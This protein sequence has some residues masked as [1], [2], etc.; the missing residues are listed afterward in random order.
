MISKKIIETWKKWKHVSRFKM[1]NSQWHF[2]IAYSGIMLSKWTQI[3]LNFFPQFFTYCGTDMDFGL[4][5]GSRGWRACER[6]KEKPCFWDWYPVQQPTWLQLQQLLS[7]NSKLLKLHFLLLILPKFENL[8]VFGCSDRVITLPSISTFRLMALSIL[9]PSKCNRS[10][11]LL[12]IWVFHV[13]F[14]ISM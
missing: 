4:C 1:H 8:A 13:S 12:Q 3:T 7:P 6:R 11:N 10:V 2:V 5:S 9:V 14:L